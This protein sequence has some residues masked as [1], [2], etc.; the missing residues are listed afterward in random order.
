MYDPQPM[1]GLTV[2]AAKAAGTECFTRPLAQFIE[3]IPMFA[4]NRR[5][6]ALTAFLFAHQQQ[7]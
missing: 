1:S 3:R 6:A 5:G 7:H 4:V 2:R